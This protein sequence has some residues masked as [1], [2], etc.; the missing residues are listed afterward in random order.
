MF[1][2]LTIPI[3]AETAFANQN[4]LPLQAKAGIIAVMGTG[5]I[6]GEPVIVEI[7]VEV[8]SGENANQVARDVL[9]ANNLK[10]FSSSGLGSDG[11]EV[12]GFFWPSHGLTQLYNTASQ[13]SDTATLLTATHS[14]WN[15]VGTSDFVFSSGGESSE[16]PSMVKE[17]PGPQVFDFE[18]TVGWLNIKNRGTLAIA[19]F[20]VH[21]TQGPETDIALNT[22]YSWNDDCTNPDGNIDVETVLRH[23]NGHAAG[24]GHSNDSTALMAPYYSGPNCNLD[25]PD[26]NE[27]IT[28]LYDNNKSGS[29]S[30][31]VTD[32]EDNPI[33]GATVELE[34]TL[35]EDITDENGDYTISNV[36]DPV[37]Y[38]VTASADGF[39]SST[40]DRL[41]VSGGVTE[42]FALTPS[43]GDD[44]G[45]GGGPPACHPRFGC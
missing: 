27:A 16:C 28:Y 44:G 36:P 35:L 43:D 9:K 7:L 13:E 33:A 2:V 29:V 24:I 32:S 26:D 8:Q 22:R 6:Q 3:I 38:T 39:G 14:D 41:P 18:N 42:D 15:G 10:P 5:H 40:I 20:A 11:F 25:H 12:T 30:G 31:T 45:G 17:C 34:G 4:D 1:L 19:Y 23:E 21:S 37:T